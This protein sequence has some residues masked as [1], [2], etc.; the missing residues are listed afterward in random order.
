MSIS[1]LQNDL[2]H[3]SQNCMGPRCDPARW[4]IW[5]GAESH[6]AP[7]GSTQPPTMQVACTLRMALRVSCCLSHDC[8]SQSS[9]SDYFLRLEIIL[10]LNVSEIMS[11]IT[12]VSN[13]FQG[14][15]VTPS[16][17]LP[18]F[19]SNL[20]KLKKFQG[21]VQSRVL[22]CPQQ[23]CVHSSAIHGFQWPFQE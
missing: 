2:L 22:V 21:L 7:R 20:V 8:Q 15:V 18:Y 10:C 14:W 9:L 12:Q 6:V 11:A 17:F 4:C 3:L 16:S 23:L 1:L 5:A 13:S 19:T